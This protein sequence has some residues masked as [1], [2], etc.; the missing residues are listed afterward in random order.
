VRRLPPLNALRAFEAAGRH[1]SFAR[2][3]DELHVTHG[4][5]SRH[6]RLLEQHLGVA[7]FH[8][9]A[10]GVELT[11]Q[12]RALLPE[13]TAS[14]ERIGLAARKVAADREI[15]VV[16]QPTLA[17]RWLVPRLQRLHDLHPDLRVSLG[18]FLEGYD[19]FYRGGFDLGF[20]CHETERGRPEGI[21][22]VPLRRL[23]LAPVCAPALLRGAPR[24]AG[25]PNWPAT[26]SCTP[27]PA[28]RTGGGGCGPPAS[29][30]RAPSTGRPSR[31]WR[32]RSAPR[33]AGSA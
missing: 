16:A 4:A 30:R 11:G 24:S 8:R 10:H 26:S 7:L 29:R 21:E 17:A 14:F 1:Q 28:G 5:V 19:E 9:R 13:L 3:A 33:R 18:L 15:R 22:A 32:W 12:G 20:G 25:R 23:V 6:V 27:R 31:R 2:A